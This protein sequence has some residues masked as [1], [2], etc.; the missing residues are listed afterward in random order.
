M[1]S[2]IKNLKNKTN[3]VAILKSIIPEGSVVQSYPFYDGA[4]EFSLCQSNRYVIGT[5]RSSVVHEFWTTLVSDPKRVSLIAE[6]LFPTLNENTFDLLKSNWYKYKDPYVRSAFFFLL[7]TCS[8]LGMI[9]H[10][11]FDAS[12]YNPFSLN[13]LKTFSVSNFYSLLIKEEFSHPIL[14]PVD[15]SLFN[16][17]KYY[18]DILSTEKV[19]GIEESSFRHTTLLKEFESKPAIFLYE[20]HPR[21][22]SLKNYSKILIDQYGRPTSDAENAKEIILHNV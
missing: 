6:K 10:G 11:E 22:Y 7:N 20:Y 19:F 13:E 1:R 4:I 18:Y 16:G 14:E 8:S 17:G 12:R 21:L 5:T 2:P 9:S 15:I 3:S